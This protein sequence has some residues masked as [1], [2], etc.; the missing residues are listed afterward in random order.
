[1]QNKDTNDE[2]N[3]SVDCPLRLARHEASRQNVD[4][5]KEPD[6]SEKHQQDTKDD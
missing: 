5:L 4:A 6:C 1:M 3:S 2:R